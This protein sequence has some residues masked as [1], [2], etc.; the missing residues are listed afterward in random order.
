MSDEQ[1]HHVTVRLVHD[2]EFV[3]EFNDIPGAPSMLF[4]EPEPL[5]GSRAPNAVDV[6]GAAIG[7]CLAASL[8]FCMRRARMD[9]QGMTASV[10]ARV[11]R[12]EEGRFRI[13][14]VDVELS[15]RLG[16]ENATHFDRCARLFK[17]FCIVTASV[18]RG[19]PVHVSLKAASSKPVGWPDR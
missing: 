11:V 18:E 9:V 6:L 15:P 3:A 1:S 7:D 16:A 5:G 14:G 10:T 12:N 4:D 2:Y 17:E 13:G 8:T 19:I